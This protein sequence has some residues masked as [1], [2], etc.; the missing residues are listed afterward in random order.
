[1]YW[2]FVLIEWHHILCAKIKYFFNTINNV[3]KA[4]YD[5][6]INISLVIESIKKTWKPL[7]SIIYKTVLKIPKQFNVDVNKE[8][9]S[10]SIMKVWQVKKKTHQYYVLV[11]NTPEE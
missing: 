5:K 1:M 11:C 2:I 3:N 10:E 7:Y 6:N 9:D 8:P 4:L